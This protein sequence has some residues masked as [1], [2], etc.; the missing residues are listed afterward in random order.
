MSANTNLRSCGSIA[1]V[2]LGLVLLFI[3]ICGQAAD[4]VGLVLIAKGVVSAQ[5]SGQPPRILGRGSE[6]FQGDKIITSKKGFVVVRL[7]DESK[8]TLRPETEFVIG[9]F[10]QTE[11]AEA[12][13]FDLLK[14]GLRTLTGAIAKRRPESYKLRTP[15]ASIGI[16]GTDY[17]ARYCGEECEQEEDTYDQYE[18]IETDCSFSL[19]GV[20]P[21]L[22]TAVFDGLVFGAK[23]NN[24]VDL[25]PRQAL[26]ADQGKISCLA[27]VPKFLWYDPILRLN[28]LSDEALELLNIFADDPT[29]GQD[30]EVSG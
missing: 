10:D 8:I 7:D 11:G 30:C 12:A 26:F 18:L 22:Y 21:G 17:A 6:V 1:R 24:I 4:V 16:R 28:T 5:V 2:G 9:K 25:E 23:K 3:A 20:P 27:L 14:G 15:V 13:E 19:D 29:K